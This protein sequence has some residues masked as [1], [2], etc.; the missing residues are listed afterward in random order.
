MYFIQKPKPDVIQQ[1]IERQRQQPFTYA[2]V[3]HSRDCP[4]DGYVID[5][6]RIRLGAGQ[7]VFAEAQAA[8]RHWEMFRLGWVVLCWPE[9]P[10]DEGTTVAVL[11][12]AFGLWSLNA[13]RI[14]YTLAEDEAVERF[15]FAYGTLPN[16]LE[17]GEERFTIEWHH[18][19]DSV[20]YDILAF[21]RPNQ[22]VAR[23]GYPLVRRLQRRFTRESMAVMRRAVGS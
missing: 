1:F 18:Q 9:A 11:G 23:L 14:V 16:H 10:L 4:P 6:N 12:Q 15:G 21:S 7:A 20:W 5:H 3:G 22:W 17:R 2:E 13:C 8:L 19:D